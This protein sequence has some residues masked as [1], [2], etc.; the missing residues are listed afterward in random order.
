[1]KI[2]HQKNQHFFP[3]S[4]FFVAGWDASSLGPG[5]IGKATGAALD[6]GEGRRTAGGG[7]G[8]CAAMVGASWAIN[9]QV[10]DIGGTD[11]I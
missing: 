7:D 4:R 9:G 3:V 11:H 5:R 10:R 8:G 2:P 1:M 6:H